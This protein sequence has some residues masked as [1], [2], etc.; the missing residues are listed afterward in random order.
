METAPDSDPWDEGE[1]GVN[2]LS[3][4]V[5]YFNDHWRITKPIMKQYNFKFRK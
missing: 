5:K 1:N 2:W 3:N 4:E